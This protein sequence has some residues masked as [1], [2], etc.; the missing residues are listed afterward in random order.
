VLLKL[1]FLMRFLAF[2]TFCY[3]LIGWLVERG[4]SAPDSKVKAFFRVLCSPV[5]GPVSRLVKPG[6]TP[7][8]LLLVSLG[9]VAAVWVALYALDT[10]LRSS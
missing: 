3:L 1:V 4:S 2:M 10:V 9:V 6:T 7:E 5:T 8:R